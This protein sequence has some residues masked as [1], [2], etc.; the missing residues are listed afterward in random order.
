MAAVEEKLTEQ[1]S[2]KSGAQNNAPTDPSCSSNAKVS[3][4]DLY[5]EFLKFTEHYDDA[6]SDLLTK[7]DDLMSSF[8]D[9]DDQ[10]QTFNLERVRQHI[11]GISFKHSKFLHSHKSVLVKRLQQYRSTEAHKSLSTMH[12]A[13][14]IGAGPGGLRMAINLALLGCPDITLIDSR[15]Y[16]S[17]KQIVAIWKITYRDLEALGIRDIL[18]SFSDASG[19]KLIP[20]AYL[21]QFL[22]RVALLLN[23]KVVTRRKLD[24]IDFE[25]K[26]IYVINTEDRDDPKREEMDNDFDVL[27]DASG[28]KAVL[29]D[30]PL[31][32]KQTPDDEAKEDADGKGE[33]LLIGRKPA[34]HKMKRDILGITANFDR[35]KGDRRKP[36]ILGKAQFLFQDEFNSK[37]V[38]LENIVYFRSDLSNYLVATVKKKSLAKYKVFVDHKKRGKALLKR[39]N[40][41]GDNLRELILQIATEWDVPKRKGDKNPFNRIR[42]ERDDFALFEF[43]HLRECAQPIKFVRNGDAVQMIACVGD[44]CQAP[45]WPKGTGVNHAFIGCYL[46]GQHIQR[47]IGNRHDENVRNEIEKKAKKD[48][49]DLAK[50][51]SDMNWHRERCASLYMKDW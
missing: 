7:F 31:N 47:W 37:A 33:H 9:D 49:D 35:V 45:F 38:R 48:F 11:K 4:N 25:K 16:F 24:S 13:L 51:L 18:P 21:Q 12:K 43:G 41:N 34:P 22:L 36:Q 10:K 26:K 29:R 50:D 17:R 15:D 20:I 44:S 46:L 28:T 40:I 30:M 19:T 1:A 42:G 27:I 32:T 5:V 8:P 23:C 39:D 6:V 2:S 3:P 14:I